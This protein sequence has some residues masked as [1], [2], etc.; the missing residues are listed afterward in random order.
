MNKQQK[1][2]VWTDGSARNG[3]VGAAWLIRAND[4]DHTGSRAITKLARPLAGHESDYA[5]LFAI[6]C[7]GRLIQPAQKVNWRLDAQNIIDWMKQGEVSSK[8]KRRIPEFMAMFQSAVEATKNL[9]VE[10]IK[11]GGANNPEL[12]TVNN[13]AR[14]ETTPGRKPVQTLER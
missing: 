9:S 11:V 7:A 1:T 10:W 3:M 12:T 4:D 2:D 6:A 8:L 13:L 5:E 14:A